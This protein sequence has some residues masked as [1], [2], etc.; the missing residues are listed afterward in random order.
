MESGM[1][2]MVL[3]VRAVLPDMCAQIQVWI[4]RGEPEM[5]EM[6]LLVRT[7]QPDVPNGPD[8]RM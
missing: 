4:R 2:E 8:Q 1:K 6:V 3:L 5:R 7:V